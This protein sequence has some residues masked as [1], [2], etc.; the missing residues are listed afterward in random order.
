[1]TGQNNTCFIVLYKEQH[2]TQNIL[3]KK[4]YIVLNSARSIVYYLTKIVV[5]TC[6]SRYLV[7]N[8]Y[9]VLHGWSERLQITRKQSRFRFFFQQFHLEACKIENFEDISD[10]SGTSS[11]TDFF[12]HEG[13]K[14]GTVIGNLGRMVAL[15]IW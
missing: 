6:N 13:R 12:G 3:C 5:G 4:K 2:N 11:R 7:R 1:M 15:L 10:V 14:S 9:F 8:K